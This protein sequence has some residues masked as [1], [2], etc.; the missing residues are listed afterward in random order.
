MAVGIL[1]GNV[2]GLYLVSIT[3]DPA[4]I[5]GTATCVEQDFTV[6]GLLATDVAVSFNMSAPLAGT[7]VG[8]VR[9]KAANTLTVNF[10]NPTAGAKDIASQLMNVLIA[11]PDVPVLPGRVS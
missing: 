11:R 2:R 1:D 4:N 3:L 9:V 7:A 10:V 6:P 5:V 8:G